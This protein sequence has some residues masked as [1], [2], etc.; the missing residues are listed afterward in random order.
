MATQIKAGPL[1]LALG[2][3]T[4][5]VG[6]LVYNFGGFQ[7]PKIFWRFWPLLL[8][9]LGAEFFIR[10][11]TNKDREVVF[12]IPSILVVGL[13]VLAGLVINA[14]PSLELNRIIEESLFENRYSYTRQWESKPVSLAEGSRLKVDNQLG[15]IL[16]KPSQDGEL[17][18]MA[19]IISYGP[20][21][22]KATASADKFEVTVEEGSTTRIFTSLSEAA[23]RTPGE[24]ILA[25]E[26][27]PGLTLELAGGN[28]EIEAGNLSGNMNINSL[29][30]DVIVSNLDGSLEVKGENGRLTAVGI[31]GDLKLTSENGEVRVEN[32]KGS[33]KVESRNGLV[34][35]ISEL[36]LE[37]VYDLRSV[38]G[39]L[40]LT[41]PGQSSLEL[42]AR[43]SNG[44][45]SV[46]GKG[47]E[48]DPGVK[49]YELKLGA[50]KGQAKLSTQNGPIELNI[51]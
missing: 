44:S 2:L 51:N 36:P 23:R 28:G 45:I 6:M 47:P 40:T 21:E 1:T 46:A 9:A 7:S 16:I 17:H 10:R 25:V 38:N 26:A 48:P 29:H 12:H 8:I 35:L 39:A 31:S 22:E 3:V 19:K 37:K 34:E 24:V 5:G 41:I 42:E 27:P 33:V 18:A 50:G 49:G 11:Y 4:A 32:P 15:S 20:N 30:G 14:L 13:L 43:T